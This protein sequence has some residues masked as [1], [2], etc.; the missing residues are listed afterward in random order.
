[1][2]FFSGGLF[3]L[4]ILPASIY[5]AIKFLP[6]AYFLNHP[7]QI[8]L[9]HIST[10]ESLLIIATMIA[11]IGVLKLACQLTFKQGLKIYAAYGR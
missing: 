3:P 10:Q 4:N 8:Y 11:W 5:T 6:T 1:M 2:E 7:L 9:G